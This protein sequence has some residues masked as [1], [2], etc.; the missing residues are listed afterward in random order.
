[1]ERRELLKTGMAA[2]FTALST[3]ALAQ[4]TNHAH[5]DHHHHAPAPG[6]FSA[7]AKS[8]AAC[9]T[10]GEACLAHCLILLGDD[11]KAMAE[12]AQSVNQMLAICASLH[13]LASQNSAYT[14]RLARLAADVCS[15]CEKACRKH[16][17][18]HAECKA[19]ADACAAC[20]KDCKAAAA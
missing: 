1:M 19:C 8:S 7:L 5:H 17:N 20:L 18:K 14:A 12:C 9:L 13:K 10:V 11:D 6:N 3:A 4:T 2:A 16:E 15:D